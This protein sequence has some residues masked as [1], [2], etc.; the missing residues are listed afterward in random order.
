[1]AGYNY[2]K[3]LPN[4]ISE[5]IE[6]TNLSLVKNELTYLP[7]NIINLKKLKILALEGNNLILST[8]QDQWIKK[9][10]KDGCIV[11]IDQYRVN[12]DI[13]DSTD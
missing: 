7:Y 3:T 2:I 1:M 6:L 12:R 11:I 9:L 5:L 13:K 10:K 4:E 8:K